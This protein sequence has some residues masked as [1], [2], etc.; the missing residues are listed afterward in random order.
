M[1]EKITTALK[2]WIDP[3]FSQVKKMGEAVSKQGKDI[4]DF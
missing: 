3:D 4:G 2:G 1:E